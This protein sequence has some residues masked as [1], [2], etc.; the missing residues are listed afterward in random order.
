MCAPN[1]K[2]FCCMV[3]LYPNVMPNAMIRMAKP[4]AMLAMP[5]RV[6][7]AEKEPS[8]AWRTLRARK[9]GTFK[10]VSSY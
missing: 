6:T 2:I 7:V 3:F 10:A 5:M 9:T 8:G 4:S 1:R